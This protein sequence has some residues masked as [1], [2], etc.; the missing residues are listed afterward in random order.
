MNKI[1]HVVMFLLI[2]GCA[3]QQLKWE[4]ETLTR[5][6]QPLEYIDGYEDGCSSGTKAA[7]NP[8]FRFAKDVRR[9]QVD[10]L[11]AQGWR[12]GFEVCKAQYQSIRI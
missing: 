6:G 2:S 8:Y 9:F 5:Q 4:R 12:D 3:A 1:L 10:E 7:G 11:Y